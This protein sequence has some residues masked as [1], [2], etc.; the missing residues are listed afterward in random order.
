METNPGHLKLRL[1]PMRGLR[2]TSV[3]VIAAAQ[4]SSRTLAAATTNCSASGAISSSIRLVTWPIS[5][6]RVDAAEHHPATGG[7]VGPIPISPS[8][9]QA[10]RKATVRT[11][12]ASCRTGIAPAHSPD[13]LVAPVRRRSV[14]DRVQRAWAQGT[15]DL[16]DQLLFVVG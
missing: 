15:D 7:R 13:A 12:R 1:R 8:T 6:V 9:R 14:A 3:L 11:T 4:H 2:L 16:V 10:R 5:A